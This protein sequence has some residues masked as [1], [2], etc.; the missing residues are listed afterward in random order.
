MEKS[1]QVT[2]LNIQGGGLVTPRQSPKTENAKSGLSLTSSKAYVRSQKNQ[3]GTY[4]PKSF[5]KNKNGIAGQ[6]IVISVD[7]ITIMANLNYEIFEKL[8]Y[9]T[10]IKKRWAR[11]SR[12][13][14]G[15]QL[16]EPTTCENVAYIEMAEFQKNRVRIDFNPNKRMDTEQGKWL[17]QF[18]SGLKYKKFSRCDI[19]FD[20]IN[21]P[22]AKRIRLF[23]HNTGQDRHT[24]KGGKLET[25]YFGRRKSEQQV[26]LY[27]KK[28]ER[29]DNDDLEAANR[30]NS[31]WRFEFQLR[32]N[33]I[34]NYED[35]IKKT[36][37]DI[38]IF[39]QSKIDDLSLWQT[40][41]LWM[42]DP[43]FFDSMPKQTKSHLKQKIASLPCIDE[44]PQAMLNTYDQSKDQLF[45]KLNSLVTEFT[46]GKN[47]NK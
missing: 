46:Q 8:V 43:E 19:A 11:I 1:K 10:L 30:F 26:R 18:I 4:P 27:D 45:K 33:K 3:S 37:A 21:I 47:S 23:S 12:D 36:L 42:N 34:P 20:L 14:A 5:D 9:K 44:I 6:K 28:K 40:C 39:D 25:I 24:G 31:W 2:K 17:L 35:Q 22:E 32:G 41:Y 29:L 16:I 38:K 7:R 15:I 13:V